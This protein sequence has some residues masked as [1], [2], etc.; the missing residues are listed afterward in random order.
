MASR[1]NTKTPQATGGPGR[2]A[3]MTAPLDIAAWA[4]QVLSEVASDFSEEELA[5]LE[6]QVKALAHAGPPAAPP[7]DPTTPVIVRDRKTLKQV[8]GQ[9]GAAAEAAI[10]LET[11]SL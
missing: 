10:D 6:A 2:G 11:S 7:P 4:R 8:A 1:R 5:V 9:I 3:D